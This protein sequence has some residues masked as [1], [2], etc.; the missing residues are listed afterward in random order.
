MNNI[1]NSELSNI[2]N[3][4]LSQ[5]T[6]WG[7]NHETA[8]TN[9]RDKFIFST[10]QIHDFRNFL[11]QKLS[12]DINLII[13]S[14]CNRTEIYLISDL[15]PIQL[16]L[17]IYNYIAEFF[18][19]DTQF[20]KE[21][22]SFFKYGI[23]VIEHLMHVTGGLK[24]MVLGEGQVISQ[25]RKAYLAQKVFITNP[26]LNQIFQKVLATGKRIRTETKITTGAVSI[27]QAC[28]ELAKEYINLKTSNIL[29]IGTGSIAKV[30][31]RFLIDYIQ[32]S[33]FDV[34][35]R[36]SKHYLRQ[37][38]PDL[39][40][41][42]LSIENIKFNNYDV[43]ICATSQS[44]IININNFQ[45][46]NIHKQLILCDLGIPCNIDQSCLDNSNIQY[47][48]LDTVKA[49]INNNLNKRHDELEHA[50]QIIEE[51]LVKFKLWCNNKLSFTS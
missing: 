9:I 8:N 29:L 6:V 38:H 33:N 32:V 25:V 30:T 19:L 2:Y 18:Y 14:T 11:Q 17:Q 16:K 5:I 1:S 37:S 13:L 15:S 47:I 22:F 34:L 36:H 44:K 26:I 3:I 42:Q 7:I 10:Q 50:H 49:K 39:N 23:G 21:Y 27:P 35:E 20:V 41:L 43:I 12:P 4:F 40:Y 31:T 24:S 28:L 45:Y 51:E 46:K 48:G